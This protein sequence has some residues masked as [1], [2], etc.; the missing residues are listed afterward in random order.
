MRAMYLRIVRVTIA[1]G[2]TEAY[3]AWAREVLDLWDEN[4]VRRA[5][6]PFAGKGAAGE[7]IATWLTVHQGEAEAQTEYQV[8]YAAGR[9][10]EIISRRPPLVA[11]TVTSLH[12]DWEQ[13][14]TDAAPALPGW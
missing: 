9:G 3:W 11:E 10:R 5:G 13:R 7:D 14:G 4:G 12:G 6:G 2:K 8:M 1:P